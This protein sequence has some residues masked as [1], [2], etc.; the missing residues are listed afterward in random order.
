MEAVRSLLDQTPRPEAVVINSGGGD[1]TPRLRANRLEVPVVNNPE[2]LLPGAARNV[3]IASTSAPIVAFLAADCIAAPGWVAGRL[4]AHRGGVAAVASVMTIQP[5]AT[6]SQCAAHLLLHHR[7]MVDTP[8]GQRLLYGLSYD[9][10][11]FGRLGGFRE[12]LRQGEDSEFNARL[13]PEHEVVLA[14]DVR[15]IHRHPPDFAGLL[16]DQYARGGRRA[17]AMR[18]LAHGGWRRVLMRHGITNVRWAVRHARR[19]RDPVERQLLMR[20]RPLL[21]PASLAYFAGGLAPSRW[22]AR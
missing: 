3:A 4:E 7:R 19:T 13:P 22:T 17:I 1:P 10:S 6:R 8:P 2:L 18:E 14:P 20:S 15:T 21:A 16:R 11:T 12:D 5:T 9:R